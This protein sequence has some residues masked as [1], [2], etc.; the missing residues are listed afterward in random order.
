MIHVE[1]INKIKRHRILRRITP[2]LPILAIAFAYMWAVFFPLLTTYEIS[3]MKI[4]V[5]A[6]NGSRY[7]YYAPWSLPFFYVVGLLPFRMAAIVAGVI[8]LTGYWWALHVFKG[9]KVLFFLSFPLGFAM[10]YGQVDGI[11]LGGFALAFWALQRNKLILTTVGLVIALVK[12][13]VFGPLAFGLWLLYANRRQKIL[14]I[15]W[16]GL[17]F[18]LSFVIWDNWI[19]ELLDRFRIRSIDSN[20]SIDLWDFTGAWILALWMPVLLS[21]KRD[22]RWWVI[23]W[24]LTTPYIQ[25]YGLTY[26][27]VFPTDGWGWWAQLGYLIGLE[28]RMLL[29][30]M[31]FALYL[32]SW[33]RS[34][35]TDWLS[36]LIARMRGR[37]VPL[38]TPVTSDST[39]PVL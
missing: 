25:I 37:S 35:Q 2:Y 3:D 36:V 5:D 34:W 28:N 14:L 30:F 39:Q 21:Q 17:F 33:Y 6:A 13:Y 18:V 26:I 22:L 15:A 29:M 1:L 4:F 20:L 8:S 7:F 27:L 31:P 32:L 10:F 12:W 24:T 23:T 11:F 38:V 19:L 16:L 9:N